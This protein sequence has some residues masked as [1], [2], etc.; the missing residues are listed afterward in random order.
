MNDT[1]F[2][3]E[4]LSPAGSFAAAHY[5]FAG[6]ADAVYFGLSR[7]SARQSAA[8]FDTDE[9]RRLKTMAA[10]Q[11]KKLY[12]AVNTLI[13]DDE[14]PELIT[15]L[16]LLDLLQIDGLIVQDLGVARIAREHFPALPLHASTQ[17]A[18]HTA[19][20]VA[21]LKE[22]G[23]RRVI[24]ARELDL[25]TIARIR[26]AHRDIELEVFIHGALCYSVSGQCL[27]SG[28][29]LGRSGNRGACAQ[30]CRSYF[31]HD[32]R[33]GHWFSC[34][35][36]ALDD[37]VRRL[38][39]LGIDGL[40]IEGRM[41]SPEYVY[42]TARL[43]RAILDGTST[44]EARAAARIIFSRTLSKGHLLHTEAPLTDTAFPGHRG[45]LLGTVTDVDNG[46]FTLTIGHPV[47]LRDGLQFFKH[48]GREPIIFSLRE[49][50]D[51]AGKPRRTARAGEK[52]TIAADTT[53]AVG[54]Q[55]FLVSSRSLDLKAITPGSYRP[56][57]R[58][59]A[60]TVRAGAKE[61]ALSTDLGS[62]CIQHSEPVDISPARGDD[63]AAIFE[64]LLFESGDSLFVPSIVAFERAD[65][66][67]LPERI[68]IPPSR[69]KR[70]KN[71]FFQTLDA[72]FEERTRETTQTVVTASIPRNISLKKFDNLL[73]LAADRTLF[74]PK[75]TINGNSTKEIPFADISALH[76]RANFFSNGVTVIPLMPFVA[77]EE[78]YFA[79]LTSFLDTI[80][81]PIV[82][83][84]N[85]IGHLPL[86]RE[87]AVRTD[88]FFFLDIFCYVA[89]RYTI[90]FCRDF[91]GD[92]I[93]FGYRWIE[94]GRAFDDSPYPL[95]LFGTGPAF[96][97]PLFISRVCTLKSIAS[98]ACPAGCSH[99]G[100]AHIENQGRHYRVLTKSGLS[101]L[102][103]TPAP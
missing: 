20:G 23:F 2:R 10:Q 84:I 55:L 33:A 88:V 29:T 39:D 50:F 12:A 5:A 25:D 56:W 77:D 96:N 27:A 61:L 21:A 78:R 15:T 60:V 71:A 99:E 66:P 49:L 93:L 73:S 14:L 54:T 35:D 65:D 91:L 38:R 32:R 53:P 44:V 13:T 74:S 19:A 58:P 40:K 47:G 83:G 48:D 70:L 82:L 87:I 68:F 100:V 11:G 85:N 46:R 42:H 94:E 76:D 41:K 30:I 8:N 26:A 89:N 67:T 37:D 86:C 22:A 52:I 62:I 24:L 36:L 72:A 28:L 45:L 95:P 102:F 34:R 9:L 92:R 6:G 75:H 1:P 69:L 3:P 31:S 64:P 63:L 101:W 103:R 43:Y 59:V 98:G 79:A 57:K 51:A 4:L 7:F 17:L 81:G 97:P 90:P 16:A 80:D 18:A